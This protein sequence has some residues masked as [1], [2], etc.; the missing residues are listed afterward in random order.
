MVQFQTDSPTTADT[1]TD[2]AGIGGG[3]QQP[4]NLNGDPSAVE[5]RPR[6]R[7]YVQRGR[8][9][10]E[11]RHKRTTQPSRAPAAGTFS[12]SQYRNTLYGPGFQNWNI[13]VFKVFG[14][15]ERHK[16]QFRGEFFNFPN[17]PNW[18]S[19]NDDP[20]SGTFGKVTQKI[21][22]RNIQLSLRYSF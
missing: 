6:L 10:V 22:E 8:L 15:N 11:R 4:W 2:F 1:D 3:P 14:I 19:P 12:T 7:R 21:S 17:H 13:G 18:D 16:I 5:R 20:A 9:L